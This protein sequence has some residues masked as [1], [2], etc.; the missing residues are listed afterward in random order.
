MKKY[1]LLLVLTGILFAC[2]KSNDNPDGSKQLTGVLHY[3]NLLGGLGMYY[4]ADSNHTT[5]IFHNEFPN[6]PHDSLQFKKYLYSVGLNTTLTYTSDG[7]TGCFD[8][9]TS[10]CGFPIVTIVRFTVR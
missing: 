10:L 9:N 8:G 1:L 5:I 4:V 6:D 2:K 3:D 7:S